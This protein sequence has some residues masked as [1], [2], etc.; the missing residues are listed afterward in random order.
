MSGFP[1]TA[2]KEKEVD[3][4]S[5]TGVSHLELFVSDLDASVAWYEAA[6]RLSVLRSQPGVYVVMQPASRGFRL[7]LRPD[8]PADAHGEFGHVALSVETVSVLHAW[9]EHLDQA[10][11]PHKDIHESPTGFTL[12]LTD[13]DGHDIELAYEH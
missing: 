3:D 4:L 11:V 5:V 12:D 8:R 7:V 13:P 6:L 10:G 9:A 2:L 1:R